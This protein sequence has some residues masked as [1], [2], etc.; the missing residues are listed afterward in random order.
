MRRANEN[1][2]HEV[3]TYATQTKV[4]RF[5]KDMGIQCLDLC[6]LILIMITIPPNSGWVERAYSH[7]DQVCRKKR[8]RLD[9]SNL[10]ELL[11]LAALK[12]KPNDSWSYKMEIEILCGDA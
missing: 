6:D 3:K 8:N 4:E 9:I 12:L 1:R 7:F 2:C 5:L 10:E 11:F